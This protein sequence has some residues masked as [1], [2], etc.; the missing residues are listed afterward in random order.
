MD[1]EE[2][3]TYILDHVISL[4]ESAGRTEAKVDEALRHLVGINGINT[5]HERRIARGEF[6]DRMWK[7][8]WGGL[9][10]VISVAAIILR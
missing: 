7:A 5:D 9:I 10:V 1:S 4:R 6:M 2:R 8:V 3:Q